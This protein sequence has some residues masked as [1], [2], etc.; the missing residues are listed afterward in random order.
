M[1]QKKGGVV[2]SDISIPQAINKLQAVK[3][4]SQDEALTLF[5]NLVNLNTI[6]DVLDDILTMEKEY[7]LEQHPYKIYYSESDKRWRTYLPLANGKRKAI[8][9]ITQE[10]LENKIIDFYKQA[11]VSVA[12]TL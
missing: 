8:T 6:D 5:A 12:D 10:N 2:I 7:Y 11:N 9:S 3:H 1:I 4:I